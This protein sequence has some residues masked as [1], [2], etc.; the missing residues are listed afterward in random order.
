M[1]FGCVNVVLSSLAKEVADAA[2]CSLPKDGVMRT[3]FKLLLLPS[4]IEHIHTVFFNSWSVPKLI[5]Q[6]SGPEQLQFTPIGLEALFNEAYMSSWSYGTIQGFTT[7]LTL[8]P[9]FPLL[10]A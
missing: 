3:S 8:F 6:T 4:L 7:P 10:F 1:S 5:F 9:I 2:Q